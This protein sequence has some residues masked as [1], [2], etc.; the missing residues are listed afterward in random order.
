MHT[1][2]DHPIGHGDTP[3]PVRTLCCAQCGAGFTVHEGEQALARKR[4][5]QVGVA[6]DPEA[7]LKTLKDGAAETFGKVRRW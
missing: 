1:K 2:P 3:A 6:G 7:L 4:R 5:L